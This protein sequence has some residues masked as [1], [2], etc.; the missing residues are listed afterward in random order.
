M[1]GT[2]NSQHMAVGGLEVE[3]LCGGS[4]KAALLLHGFQTI[5]PKAPF[6]SELAKHCS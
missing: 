5:S 1:T 4:G 2:M 6:L 3:V